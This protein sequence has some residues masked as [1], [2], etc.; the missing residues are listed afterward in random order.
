MNKDE[1]LA[2][3]N[4]LEQELMKAELRLCEQTSPSKLDQ[5]HAVRMVGRAM[6]IIEACGLFEQERRFTPIY[7]RIINGRRK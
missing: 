3:L 4:F 2:R 5:F 7:F 1:A 6:G